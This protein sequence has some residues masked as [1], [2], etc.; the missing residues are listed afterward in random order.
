MTHHKQ[1]E[2]MKS[3]LFIAIPISK[4]IQTLSA[5][6]QQKHKDLDVRW[7]SGKNL[8]I[9]LIAPWY[10]KDIEKVKK[11]LDKL[12]NLIGGFDISLKKLAFGPSKKIP[13][14][15][16]AEG[17]TPEKLKVLRKKLKAHEKKPFR[18]HMT[19]ARFSPKK[20]K[21]QNLKNL[22]K[23]INWQQKAY[24]IVLMQSHLSDKPAEYE[25]LHTVKL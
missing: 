11:A 17:P 18:L 19:I 13:S 3:R 9:T 1:L 4:E 5:K 6:F 15:M 22:E 24:S 7:T 10:E 21:S 2:N 14:L 8:H 23:S 25:I 16:W 12:E 20:F